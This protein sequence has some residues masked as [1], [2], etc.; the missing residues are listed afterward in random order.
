MEDEHGQTQRQR[1]QTERRRQAKLLYDAAQDAGGLERALAQLDLAA[2][3]TELTALAER[4]HTDLAQLAYVDALADSLA[5]ATEMERT[6]RSEL[7]AAPSF[8][9]HAERELDRANHERDDAINALRIAEQTARDADERARN[10]EDH[11]EERS[12]AAATAEQAL[13]TAQAERDDAI[14]AAAEA[15]TIWA[16]WNGPEREV[17]ELVAEGRSN[18]GDS[19][20]PGHHA[21]RRAEARERELQQAGP[22]R[23]RGRRPA[24]PRGARLRA[25]RD[26]IVSGPC[27]GLIDEG[28]DAALIRRGGLADGGGVI[29]VREVPKLDGPDGARSF[30]TPYGFSGAR[31]RPGAVARSCD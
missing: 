8:R 25:A 2:T 5:K 12:T 22:S 11:A 4:I 20:T 21:G 19:R 16:L 1:R 18:K 15:D 30:A 24:H 23:G 10:A 31:P 13:E 6:A 7:E 14:T 9:T 29:D 28:R 27:V 17:L 3:V 26:L